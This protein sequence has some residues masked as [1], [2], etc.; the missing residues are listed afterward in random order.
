MATMTTVFTIVMATN[1]STG[2]MII[3]IM[4]TMAATVAGPIIF[5]IMVIQSAT[6]MV[7]MVMITIIMVDY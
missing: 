6:V 3:M 5:M 2:T 1:I 4:N 7:T